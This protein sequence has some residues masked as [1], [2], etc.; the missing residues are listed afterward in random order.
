MLAAVAAAAIGFA[1]GLVRYK[2]GSSMNHKCDWN[3]NRNKI[4]T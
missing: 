1:I 3:E 4:V 2:R